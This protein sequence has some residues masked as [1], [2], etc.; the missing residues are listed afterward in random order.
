MNWRRNDTNDSPDSLRDL[1]LDAA[2]FVPLS[3]IVHVQIC[4][5]AQNLF[6]GN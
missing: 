3:Y 1:G 2:E 5:Y 6:A 4:K